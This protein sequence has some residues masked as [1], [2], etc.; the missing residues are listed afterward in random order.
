M[1]VDDAATNGMRE[2]DE[3]WGGLRIK[4]FRFGAP[5]FLWNTV[6]APELISG[7]GELKIH[8]TIPVG[9]PTDSI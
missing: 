7:P 5:W 6:D 8:V 4:S 2:G 9:N 1:E 3:G